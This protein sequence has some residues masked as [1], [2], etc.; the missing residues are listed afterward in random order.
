MEVN[1]D[2]ALLD[3][4]SDDITILE[5]ID[6]HGDFEQVIASSPMT[7]NVPR[8]SLQPPHGFEA[9][10]SGRSAGLRSGDPRAWIPLVTEPPGH[11]AALVGSGDGRLQLCKVGG[12]L[13]Q[14]DLQHQVPGG[15]RHHPQVAAAIVDK[16]LE[17]S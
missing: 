16:S 12:A 14:M 3:E 1:L 5:S 17:G 7:G 15:F 2:L 10:R 8:V 6:V 4:A 9:Q 11:Q 13:R